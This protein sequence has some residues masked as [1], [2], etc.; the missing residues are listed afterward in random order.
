MKS[1]GKTVVTVGT[2][3]G[4]H[5]GHQAILREV[6]KISQQKGLKAI[7]YAFSFPPRF[8]TPGPHLLLTPRMKST[9]LLRY[10]TRVLHA[11]FSRVRTLSPEEF[12]HRILR[13]EL[14]ADTVVVGNN[15]RF[16]TDRQGDA[17][18]LKAFGSR[19]GFSVVIVPPVI[20]D[21]K[22]VSSTR[23]RELIRVGKVGPA[24]QLLGRPPIVVGKVIP[25][26]QIGSKIGFPT[27]NLALP[28]ELIRPG[29]G[30]YLCYAFWNKKGEGGLF[31]IGNRPTIS[32]TETRFEL[33]LL[34]PPSCDLTGKTL[35]VHLLSR[36]RDERKFPS[37]TALREQISSDVA[38]ARVLLPLYPPP[39]PI[40]SSA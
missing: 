8:Q 13:D 20:M 9:L 3:D 25:G 21:G 2:F 26:N 18:S 12:V 14:Q 30:I 35:E 5:L 19:Y 31:Y 10:V 17:N 7:A 27:A 29:S 33:H 32:G 37:L 24:R 22:A 4:V 28:R 16:G 1:R 23:I 6:R 34:S 39:E 36:L 40:L 11:E 38:S 15:F